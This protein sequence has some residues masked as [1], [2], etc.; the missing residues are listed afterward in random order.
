[1]ASEAPRLLGLDDLVG[2]DDERVELIGG[3]LVVETTSFAHGVAQVA[4]AGEIRGHLRGG[5][6]PPDDGWWIASEVDVVYGEH[7]AFRHDVA[8]WR[9]ARVPTMPKERR[10]AIRPDWVCE[11]LSTNR[12]KDLRDKRRVL[13]AC[14]VPHYWLVDLDAPLLTVLRHHADG[15]V[16]VATVAPGEVARLEPFHAVELDVAVLFGA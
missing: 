14:G 3:E 7:D 15:Y 11:I 13:H 6:S 5:G 1:M 4:I 16:I 12:N 10:V 8:G 9:R 2:L